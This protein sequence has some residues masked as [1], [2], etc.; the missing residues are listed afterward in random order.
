MNSIN[1]EVKNGH[2]SVNE[3]PLTKC[4]KEKKEIFLL[5]LRM[6][7]F[8]LP[9]QQKSNSSFKKRKDEVK[10]L[11]NYKFANLRHEKPIIN[12]SNK[13]LIFEPKK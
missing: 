6:K 1:L 10:R 12:I 2:W 3:K 13:E 7:K 8:K 9:I 4:S 5:H 11:Y